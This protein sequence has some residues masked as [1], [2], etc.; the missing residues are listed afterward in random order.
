M[1]EVYDQLKI[2][3]DSMKKSI[4]MAEKLISVNDK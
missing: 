3:A 4:Q 1:V 2:I